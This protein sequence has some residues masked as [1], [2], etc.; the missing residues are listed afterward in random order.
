VYGDIPDELRVLIEPVVEDHGCELVD[1]EVK[2]GSGSGL[3]RITVD[4]AEGDGR[5]SIDSCEEVSR[6]IEVQLDAA[7][8][9][10]QS[11]RLE[12]S[13]PGL[14][15]VLAREKD[16]VAARGKDV[17]LQTRHALAGRRRFRG[18]L[19]RFENSVV[20]IRVDGEDVDVPFEQIE[21]ANALYEFSRED[22]TGGNSGR[23][24]K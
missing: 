20:R 11:Y 2:A 16:F 22:F 10:T 5:V 1:V 24:S 6:E 4:R 7:E 8:T 13:S 23:A 3:L 18:K 14:D 19:V 21:K 17:K 9:L 12:V 15:R